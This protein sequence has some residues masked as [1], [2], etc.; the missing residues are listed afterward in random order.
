MHLSD[1]RV[2]V[3]GGAGCVG[4]NLIERL[5][6][7][8]AIVRATLHVKG[9]VVVDNRVEYIRCDLTKAKDCGRAVQG[10]R[11]VFLCAGHSVGGA[12]AMPVENVVSNALVSL[13]MLRAASSAGVS[14]LLW[15]SS[16]TGYPVSGRRP[17]E[18]EE[19]FEGK[20]FEKYFL[21]GLMTRFTEA[22]CG[23]YGEKR[24]EGMIPIVLRPTSIYGPNDNFE[25]AM[26]QVTAAL[27]K[28]VVE[29]QDPIEVW[30][31]GE[32]VRDLIYV[33]DVVDAMLKAIE[34]LESYS[35]INVGL[36][37]GYSVRE[38]LQMILEI[39]GYKDAR[40][41][42][43][44]SKPT[45]IPIRLVDTRKAQALLGFKAK[46]DLREGLKKTTQ[47]YRQKHCNSKG[48]TYRG[49]TFGSSPESVRAAGGPRNCDRCWR[50]T[51]RRSGSQGRDG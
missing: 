10:M 48:V 12:G 11:Y 43:D 20:P 4:S 6:V 1:Q 21:V 15:L 51:S 46:T 7:V 42:F 29:R 19:M 5:L 13:Q 24:Q 35:A 33:D 34:R 16:T 31:T 27:I 39:D 28:K 26:S 44:S 17:I 23:V 30:G 25:P 49:V 22:L 3:A 2:L 32:D 9:P 38:I 8:G 45:T 50:Y 41:V 14:K 40:V 36:G 37:K 18:E 47:W